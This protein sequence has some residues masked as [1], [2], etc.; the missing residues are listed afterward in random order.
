MSAMKTRLLAA[1]VVAPKLSGADTASAII[2]T[3][4]IDGHA[5]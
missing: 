5:T 2:T 3:N 1:G 4:T